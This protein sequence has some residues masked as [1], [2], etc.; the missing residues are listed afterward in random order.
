M[1]TLVLSGLLLLALL[2]LAIFWSRGRQQKRLP[3]DMQETLFSPAER[4][5]L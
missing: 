2:V 1:N 4:S 3:Y 5:F